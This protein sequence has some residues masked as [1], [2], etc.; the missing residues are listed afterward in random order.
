MK[1][2]VI[3]ETQ[4]DRLIKL[5]LETK[6][7]V[8]VQ[9]TIK[10]GDIVRI[11]YKN[12]TNNFKVLQ[13]YNGQVVMDNI[14]KG[15]ANINYRYLMT[16]T[17]LDGNKLSISRV[18][19]IKEPKKLKDL[20]S[21]QHI[22]VKD[23]TNIEVLRDGEVIDTVDA[24]TSKNQSVKIDTSKK[25]TESE[26]FKNRITDL[27][28][29]LTNAKEGQGLLFQM[30]NGNKFTFCVEGNQAH[31]LTL[32]LFEKSPVDELNKW[33][34]FG[35]ILDFKGD[36]EEADELYE[37]NKKVISTP[38]GGDTISFKLK[39]FSGD[40]TKDITITGIKDI[41][42]LK[43]CDGREDEP[44][45]EPEED[46]D[47]KDREEREKAIKHGKAVYNAIIAN[48]D[49]RKAFFHQPMLFGLV[50]NG[51]PVGI[52][53][54]EKILTRF[55]EKKTKEKFGESFDKFKYN[56]VVLFEV[57]NK[58]IVIPDILQLSVGQEYR[59]VVKENRIGV[60]AIR[61]VSIKD[62]KD[63]S[64][65][66]FEMEILSPVEGEPNTYNVRLLSNNGVAPVKSPENGKIR[67]LQ[68]KMN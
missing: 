31:K 59:M 15:S 38:D 39:G 42:L 19:K 16:F 21:W 30:V 26:E 4:Y 45:A 35:F 55:F 48:P 23:I 63:K 28:F 14:D 68:Y 53:P 57:L 66:Y 58:D 62:A 7:D 64:Q 46:K 6:F 44:I 60:E 3:S 41:I 22:D 49:L 10:P 13:N 54:A 27:I 56:N 61:M 8:L 9:K 52:V 18:H 25:G 67:V 32:T 37:K 11:S 50:K 1:K 17:A 47:K 33:D 51:D 5:L 29:S 36:E 12:S 2:L 20:K 34:S 24:P 43:Y 65:P 40:R